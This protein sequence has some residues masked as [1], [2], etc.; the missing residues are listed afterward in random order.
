VHEGDLSL[1]RDFRPDLPELLGLGLPAED[2]RGPE[3]VRMKFGEERFPHEMLEATKA[4]VVDALTEVS[5]CPKR[6]NRS[7]WNGWKRT[8]HDDFA[9]MRKPYLGCS[10][11]AELYELMIV[12]TLTVIGLASR[13]ALSRERIHR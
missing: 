7:G 3:N 2:V 1:C 5:R 9:I 10:R 11:R 6:L 13:F 4:L 8:R 12:G